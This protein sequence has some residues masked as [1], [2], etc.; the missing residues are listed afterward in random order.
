MG[1]LQILKSIGK[2]NV[3]EIH[4]SIDYKISQSYLSQQLNQLF[5]FKNSKE[6]KE[7]K[8]L[9][10]VFSKD[11]IKDVREL[12]INEP[13]SLIDVAIICLQNENIAGDDES[14]E[15]IVDEFKKKFLI[16]EAMIKEWF[17]I[18]SQRQYS[19]EYSDSYPERDQLLTELSNKFNLEKTKVGSITFS[20]P[21]FTQASSGEITRGPFIQPLYAS[22]ESSKC[23]IIN[24]SSL[25]N[26]YNFRK[27]DISDEIYNTSTPNGS[28]LNI[29]HNLI[30]F[31]PTGTGK[32]RILHDKSLSVT[33]SENIFRVTL[34]PEYTYGDF[35]GTFRPAPKYRVSTCDVVFNHDFSPTKE[36]EKDKIPMIDYKFMPGPMTLSIERAL[37][38]SDPIILIIEELNRGNTSSIFGDFFQLLDRTTHGNS[39]FPIKSNQDALNF[40]RMSTGKA[41]S[42][43]I[44]LPSN[45]YIWCSLNPADQNVYPI[46]TAFKR[47]WDWDYTPIDYKSNSG[48]DFIIWRNKKIMW[49]EFIKVINLKICRIP[50]IRDDKLLGQFFIKPKDRGDKDRFKHKILLYLWEDVVPH[51]THDLFSSSITS[52]QDLCIKYDIEDEMIFTEELEE[53]IKALLIE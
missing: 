4:H 27:L 1:L 22:L 16:S 12:W 10:V 48:N 30:L 15:T 28:S 43:G 7:Q 36:I 21:Y 44:Y 29:S 32:S 37:N 25:L 40:L 38:T 42:D 34:H 23:L 33:S 14:G 19:I 5:S 11:W 13:P 17:S 6:A 18:D 51:N 49:L 35:I 39:Q 47:R 31:G 9:W 20:S 46:D 53:S 24:D 26:K 41:L 3:T 52:F 8:N 45:L 50:G 2:S